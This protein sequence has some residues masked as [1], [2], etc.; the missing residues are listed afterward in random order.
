MRNKIKRGKNDNNNFCY[1]FS[2]GRS[3]INNI[4]QKG[5]YESF[6]IMELMGGGGGRGGPPFE[7]SILSPKKKKVFLTF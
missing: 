5:L 3:V 6:P 4:K 1:C 7:F 2:S